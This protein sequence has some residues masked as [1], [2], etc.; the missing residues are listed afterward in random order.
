[1]SASRKAQA[2]VHRLRQEHPGA[3]DF[4]LACAFDKVVAQEGLALQL[5]DGHITE[6]WLCTDCGVNTA[7]GVPDGAETIAQLNSGAESVTCRVDC[8]SEI[9]YVRDAIWKK[10][11]MEPHSG[12]LCI[13]CLEKRLG[14]RLKPKD[15]D[16]NHPFNDSNIP[17]TDRL[18]NRRK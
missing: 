18:R 17:C 2:I 10:A 9:Y 5:P 3:S 16:R 7:P 15:F 1:S 12:C 8:D 4:E 13:G 14:R 6:D 11:G